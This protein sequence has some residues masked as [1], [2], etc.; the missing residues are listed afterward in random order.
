MAK[1]SAKT[2]KTAARRKKAGRPAARRSLAKSRVKS[3]V[4]SSAKTTTKKRKKA[5]KA[6]TL[7]LGERVSSAFK[8]VTGTIADVGGLRKKLEQPGSDETE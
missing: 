8:T 2:K 7:T 1:R 5:R 4:K 6:K 3:R